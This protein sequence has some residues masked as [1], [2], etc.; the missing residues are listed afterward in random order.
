M[1]DHSTIV[2]NLTANF[3]RHFDVSALRVDDCSHF[4]SSASTPSPFNSSHATAQTTFKQD[5][6]ND[7]GHI[8]KNT[9]VAFFYNL[10]SLEFDL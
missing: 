10:L 6:E 1:F 5:L 7:L 8:E 9:K 3:L 4:V 2:G